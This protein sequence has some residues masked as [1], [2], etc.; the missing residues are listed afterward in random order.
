MNNGV[1]LGLFAYAS[2]AFGDAT[3][4][5]LGS[6]ISVFQIGFFNV[7][8]S[9]VLIYF[10]KPKSEQWR[11]F[12]KMSMP[13]AV[14]GRAMCGLLAGIFSIYA[15]THV[16]LAEAYSLIFLA[17]MIVTLLSAVFLGEKVG[18]WRWASVFAGLCGVLLVVRPGFK[19]FELGH[20]A[21]IAVAVVAALTSVLLRSMAGREKRSSIMGT[22]I[23]YGLVGNA[24]LGAS[25]FRVPT[26]V[27]LGA[28]AVVGSFTAI[29]QIAF[30]VA[31]RLVPASH[32]APTHYSQIGWAVL[33]GA[34]FFGELPDLYTYLGLSLIVS[35]GMI[36]MFREKIKLGTIRWIPFFRSRT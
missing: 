4:K 34:V 22:L 3:I 18:L 28:L 33:L 25:T 26:M 15:F 5:A 8:F 14:H 27:E 19:A 11:E 10:S 1:L 24:V 31:A 20:M 35:A 12:W 32:I 23:L 30:L 2:F 36:T 21:A 29:G 6:D 16:P 9:S 13:I 7:L 17:P